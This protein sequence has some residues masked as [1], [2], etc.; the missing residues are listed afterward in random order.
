MDPQSHRWK[1]LSYAT[2]EMSDPDQMRVR[3]FLESPAP[4]L[5]SL[6]LCPS[7]FGDSRVNFAGGVAKG[8]RH[9]TLRSANLWQCSVLLDG[10]ETLRLVF[11][12]AGP[13]EVLSIFFRSPTLRRLDF[14]DVV[15]DQ[16]RATAS[17]L[18]P[19]LDLVAN[20]LEEVSLA[21]DPRLITLILSQLSMPS[22]KSLELATNFAEFGDE[23]LGPI[24]NDGLAQF[25]PRIREALRLGGV[26]RFLVGVGPSRYREKS[27]LEIEGFRLSFRWSG[28]TTESLTE[29]IRQLIAKLD[30]PLELEM[31]LSTPDRP[32]VEA[33]DEWNE[34]NVTKLTILVAR[35]EPASMENAVLVLDCLGDV[36]VDQDG[37]HSWNFPKLRELD[38]CST[39][40]DLS[41]LLNMLNKRYLPDAY[42]RDKEK[43]GISIQTPPRIDLRVRNTTEARGATIIAAIEKHWGVISL[44]KRTLDT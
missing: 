33:L 43:L 22:C 10:L 26:A 28:I 29:W 11:V 42:V 2:T 34:L 39:Q 23:F 38:V 40:F 5:Q 25:I 24:L 37:G 20:S 9:L 21:T 30:F 36:L 14:W 32:T 44:Q 27:S 16:S 12:E 3:H 41:R 13:A 31:N 35:P 4:M 8:L 17:A 7:H 6:Y 18:L 1:M 19:S 15:W